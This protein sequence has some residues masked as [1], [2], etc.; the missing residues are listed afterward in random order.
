MRNMIFNSNFIE[1]LLMLPQFSHPYSARVQVMV[2]RQI[3]D[4]PLPKPVLAKI[5]DVYD[6]PNTDLAIVQRL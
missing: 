1:Y 2:C 4:K 5:Y 6:V 3:G